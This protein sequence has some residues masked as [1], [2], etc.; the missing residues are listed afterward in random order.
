MSS[1]NEAV[2]KEQLRNL[3]S[4]DK[5][6][7]GQML[8]TASKLSELDNENVRFSVDANLVKRLGEQLVAK[9]TTALSELIKNSYDADAS[10]VGV[11]FRDT[12]RPN[13]EIIIQDTGSG[14]TRDQ[15][16][17]G[18]MRIST[19]DKENSPNSPIYRRKRAGR[20][21][22]GRFAA[23]KLGKKLKVITRCSANEPFLILDIDWEHFAP[24][25]SLIAVSNSTKYSHEDYGF[26]KGTKLVVSDVREAWT[27]SNIET[28]FK[29]ASSVIKPATSQ[30]LFN[31]EDPGF[32]IEF[33]SYFDLSDEYLPLMNEET[34]FLSEADA[35]IE[36][37]MSESGK[38]MIRILGKNV[39]VEE[40]LS[41]QELYSDILRDSKFKFEADYFSLEKGRKHKKHLPDFLR[42]NGGIKLYRNGFYVSPYGKRFDD[43]LNLDESSRRRL[44]LPPHANTNFIGM[45]SVSDSEGRIFDET[46]SRE[47]L[48][49]NRAFEILVETMYQIV[50]QAVS[51]ITP[52]RGR[53][54]TSN[55]E[56][57]KE[58]PIE[59]KVEEQVEIVKAAV[60]TIGEEINSSKGNNYNSDEER[61]AFA[62][63]DDSNSS[64]EYSEFNEGAKS[65]FEEEVIK[66]EL[67]TKELI[68]E[69]HMYKVLA[70][71]GLAIGEFTHEIQLYLT[72]LRLNTS[73]LRKASETSPELK[74]KADELES[75]VGMLVAYTD[76][77]DGSIRKNS[78]REKSYFEVRDIIN[79][80]FKAMKPTLDRRLYELD[81]TYDSWDIWT[82]PIHISEIS[83]V[84][85]NLFTNSCK[86]IVRSGNSPGKIGVFVTTTRE[87]IRIRFEDNGDGIPTKNWGRIFT[88]LFTTS[89]S[90]KTYGS[91]N[92]YARGMGLGLTISQ[93][94]IEGIDGTISVVE[95]SNSYNTCI[96]FVVP[97]ASEEE[98]PEDAY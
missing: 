41:F 92:E 31:D 90:D 79:D 30:D 50:K 5:P 54:V 17:N 27:K 24:N 75:N 32:S 61:D 40:E 38:C 76:F 20:K 14:M 39:L 7:Y 80:F 58:K 3:L 37:W 56:F 68:D 66:L 62:D 89:V 64:G 9:K 74:E 29:Y 21:G 93:Q 4:D 34:E 82:K 45:V 11:Y 33:Y 1:S 71:T 67:L 2:L 63:S 36:A 55:Q 53:K 49:E 51:F 85:I 47:G 86:A 22:L 8:D 57:E 83:S 60:E 10:K 15:L 52:F 84:L 81:I 25:K 78:D 77:F 59:E 88:P 19:S 6:D 96:E 97:R 70:S 12:E 42:E 28:S 94:L 87:D 73:Y 69:S 91:D 23:Q 98:I 13:G 35:S 44:I 16:I 72:A 65:R 26:D 43:W 48:I 18:F 46:S 95:P